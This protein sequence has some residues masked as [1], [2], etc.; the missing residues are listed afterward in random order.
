[1]AEETYWF[2]ELGTDDDVSAGGKGA[3]LGEFAL[4]GF[5]VLPGFGHFGVDS[6][7]V[8]PDAVDRARVVAAERRLLLDAARR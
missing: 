3:N 8:K 2:D 6:I 4:A 7:S 1:M 5:P